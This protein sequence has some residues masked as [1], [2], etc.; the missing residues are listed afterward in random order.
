MSSFCPFYLSQGKFRGK[1]MVFLYLFPFLLLSMYLTILNADMVFQ[2][3]SQK[4]NLNLKENHYYEYWCCA[5]TSC[6]K[7]LPKKILADLDGNLGCSYYGAGFKSAEIRKVILAI[8]SEE[9]F[10]ALKDFGFDMV[11]TSKDHCSGTDRVAEVVKK[12][13]DAEVIINIQGDEPLI[14]ANI[15]DDLLGL[16]EDKDV[17][18]G[19]AIS[20]KLRLMTF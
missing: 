11:M 13:E 17:N 9:T 14:D 5:S 20:T 4:K 8:D 16:F 12:N 7:R 1:I 18:M 2:K 6:S 15:I 19:T 10:D 3:V